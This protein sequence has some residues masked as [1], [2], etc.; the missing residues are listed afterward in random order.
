[1]QRFSPKFQE[2]KFAVSWHMLPYT[3]HFPIWS[4]FFCFFFSSYRHALLKA[5]LWW[6]YRTASLWCYSCDGYKTEVE[7]SLFDIWALITTEAV[8]TGCLHVQMLLVR[9]RRML[10]LC[11]A[12]FVSP[13]LWD[14]FPMQLDGALH[15]GLSIVGCPY[16][17]SQ[18]VWS[19]FL[20]CNEHSAP[21]Y[22]VLCPRDKSF[23]CSAY[24]LRSPLHSLSKEISWGNKFFSLKNCGVLLFCKFTDVI[25]KKTKILYQA[26]MCKR[27]FYILIDLLC[28]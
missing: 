24:L 26:V 19:C 8:R 16:G 13:S 4:F 5:H 23:Q 9:N 28:Y 27:L 1:M 15:A 6:N 11:P 3:S 25:W 14:R 22:N 17:Q 21:E 2:F 10:S 7:Q 18:Q 12:A 20:Q